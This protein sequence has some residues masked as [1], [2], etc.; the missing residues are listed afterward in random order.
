MRQLVL[1]SVFLVGAAV[2]AQQPVPVQPPAPAA[3]PAPLPIVAVKPIDPP[4]TPLP[5]E[6]A[7]AGVTRFSFIAYGDTRSGSTP[8]VPGDGQIVH[9]QHSALVDAMLAKARELAATPFPVGSSSSRATWS[10]AASTAA[11]GT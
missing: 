5:T 8:G 9:P 11:C 7:S 10:C 2:A 1:L 3:P 6:A 4:A